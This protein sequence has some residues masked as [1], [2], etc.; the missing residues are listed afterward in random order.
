[1]RQ[2]AVVPAIGLLLAGLVL[3]EAKPPLKVCMLSGSGEYKSDESL[4]A[5]KP[6]LESNYNI[7]CTLVKC[8][9]KGK[10]LPGI[11]ALKDCDLMFV[12]V[13]R[14]TL[15]EDQLKVVQEYCEA[16]RPVVGIRTAS[17]AFQ[18]WL[19]FDK[20]VLGGNYRGHYGAGAKAQIA[21]EEKAK[22]HPVLKGVEPFASSYSLYKNTGLA[23]DVTLLA[24]AAAKGKTEPVAWTRTH[25]GG[26]VFYTSFGG[27][28]DFKDANF[29]QMLVNAI[30]W[31]TKRDVEKK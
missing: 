13:R 26:R 22:G 19:E 29:K 21:F 7:T 12:F 20:T 30:F 17:H 28:D 6:F 3:A 27:P 16:G 23:D 25:K 8:G 14:N 24:T 11:E 15:P 31:T 18:N 10:G 1:M 9:D 5:F 2:L 4:T